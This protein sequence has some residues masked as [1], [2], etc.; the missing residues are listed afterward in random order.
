VLDRSER[1]RRQPGLIGPILAIGKTLPD[2]ESH[3]A[4][5]LHQIRHSTLVIWGEE[6]RVFLP[7]VG[8]A[9]RDTITGSRLTL[10]PRAGHIPQ[11]EQPEAVNHA[12]RTFLES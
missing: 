11:W 6:D 7:T 2:W 5:R 3:Y 8:Q 4:P 12:I 9:L 10:V 1:N